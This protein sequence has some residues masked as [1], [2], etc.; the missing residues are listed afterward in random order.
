MNIE[1][2][3]REA[4]VNAWDVWRDKSGELHIGLDSVSLLPELEV[5]AALIEKQTRLE[6]YTHNEVRVVANTSI[7]VDRV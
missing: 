4:G 5:F 1:E 6:R 7:G 3:A 2:L